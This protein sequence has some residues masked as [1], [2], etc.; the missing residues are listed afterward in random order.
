[1]EDLVNSLYELNFM[2]RAKISLHS[3]NNPVLGSP[4]RVLG[5]KVKQ[6]KSVF[7][8]FFLFIF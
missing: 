4:V 3:K 2:D 6:D 7:F 5:M 8:Y 1:M